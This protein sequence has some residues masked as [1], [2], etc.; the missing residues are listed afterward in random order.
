MTG[1]KLYLRSNQ[2]PY[3]FPSQNQTTFTLSSYFLSKSLYSLKS[4]VSLNN[5]MMLLC[6]PLS[7]VVGQ[8]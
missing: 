1:Y 6:Y 7:G 2:Y 5:L 3:L 8:F 4:N